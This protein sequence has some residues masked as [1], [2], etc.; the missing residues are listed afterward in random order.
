MLS[1]IF[2]PSAGQNEWTTCMGMSDWVR[3]YPFDFVDIR[4]TTVKCPSET[5]MRGGKCRH[6]KRP[7]EPTPPGPGP[8]SIRFTIRY[9]VSR[10]ST[11]SIRWQKCKVQSGNGIVVSNTVIVEFFVIKYYKLYRLYK[12]IKI[13]ELLDN[14]ALLVLENE[15]SCP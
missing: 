7:L 8:G 3:L 14:A 15:K 2:S 1:L 13:S 11:W 5:E 6:R 9:Y 10:I 12:F 4:W